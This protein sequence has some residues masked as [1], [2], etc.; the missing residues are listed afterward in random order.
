VVFVNVGEVKDIHYTLRD[1]SDGIKIFSSKRRSL[2]S[3]WG[4]ELVTVVENC[5]LI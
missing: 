1:S 5:F 2:E 4:V 3:Y